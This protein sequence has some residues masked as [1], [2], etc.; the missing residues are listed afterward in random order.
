M[1]FKARGAVIWLAVTWLLMLPGAT[2]FAADE[3][4]GVAAE[5]AD[6]VLL[7]R[8]IVTF[9]AAIPGAPPALRAEA[10]RE[11]AANIAKA[12]GPLEVTTAPLPEGTAVLVDG[13]L[14]FRILHADVSPALNRS[15][16]SSRLFSCAATFCR[17]KARRTWN[18]R[19]ST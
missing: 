7:N 19:A 16:V 5:P 10:I 8:H 13:V 3:A 11:R 9:R 18:A 1:S 2:A 12:G 4:T 17:A 14:L 6:L 15:L